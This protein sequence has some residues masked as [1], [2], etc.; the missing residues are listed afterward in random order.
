MFSLI[1]VWINGWVH[2]RKAGDLRRHRGHYDVI[3]MP[4]EEQIDDLKTTDVYSIRSSRIQHNENQNIDEGLLLLL[5]Y[6]RCICFQTSNANIQLHNRLL[7]IGTLAWFAPMFTDT[8]NDIYRYITLWKLDYDTIYLWISFCKSFW[9]DLIHHSLILL[10]Y[11]VGDIH[12]SVMFTMQIF[13]QIGTPIAWA[14]Y[15]SSLLIVTW[16]RGSAFSLSRFAGGKGAEGPW[17]KSCRSPSVCFLH[18]DTISLCNL[19]FWWKFI[20]T[21][22]MMYWYYS[23]FYIIPRTKAIDAKLWCFLRSAPE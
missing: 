1:C 18:I 17:D 16:Y 20:H 19:S 3:V 23:L 5:N 22:L 21:R 2:N 11:F 12:S 4:Q 8:L 14:M 9:A 13:L 6:K 10:S 15:V 7:N